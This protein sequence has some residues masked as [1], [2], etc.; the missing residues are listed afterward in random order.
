MSAAAEPDLSRYSRQTLFEP[1]G[2]DGQ[3]RLLDSCAVVVGCGALGTVASQQLVRAGVGSVRI[4]DRDTVDLS[5]LQRQVLFDEDDVA[6]GLPKAEAAARKLTRMN[7]TVTVDPRIADLTADTAAELLGGANV[8]VDGTD[9]F[10][11][12]LIVNDWAVKTSTP[13]IYCGVVSSAVHGLSVIPGET[14]CFRCYLGDLPPVGSVETCETAGVIA[15]AVEI[16]AS[17]AVVEALKILVGCRE[18]I[19]RELLILDVWERSHRGVGLSRDPECRC[20]GKQ[21][22]EFLRGERADAAVVL[23]GRNAIQLSAPGGSPIDLV[24]VAKNLTAQGCQVSQ[25]DYLLRAQVEGLDLTV[26]P[27]GRAIVK[28]TTDTAQARTIYARYLGT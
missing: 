19:C 14:P 18:Q 26:F 2:K 11:T 9:N 24:T 10:L 3:R 5:N 28:G 1:I 21:D 22:Y 23:C 15:P 27:D 17:Y 12:R 25:N 16:G 7:G 20:C 13:W 8:V 6:A 4:I